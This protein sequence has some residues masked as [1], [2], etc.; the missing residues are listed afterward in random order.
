MI[1]LLEKITAAGGDV[2]LDD[3]EVRLRIPK[4]LLTQAE[5]QLL[6]E[7]KVEIV[8]LLAVE[9]VENVKHGLQIEPDLDVPPPSCDQCGGFMSWWDFADR[10]HC[11]DCDPAV[12]SARVRD[13]AEQ[14]R[15]RSKNHA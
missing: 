5:R 7:N 11:M 9:P 15:N 4:A 1:D 8:R 3:G 14:I 2:W 12:L 6:A 10:H 13:Q